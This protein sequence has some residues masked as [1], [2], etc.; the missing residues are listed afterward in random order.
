ML[1]I[2]KI[3]RFIHYFIFLIGLWY[4]IRLINISSFFQEPIKLGSMCGMLIR[5]IF[6]FILFITTLINYLNKKS[7]FRLFLF[8][9]SIIFIISLFYGRYNGSFLSFEEYIGTSKYFDR[10]QNTICK[11]IFSMFFEIRR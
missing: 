3:Y 11:D 10:N 1:F 6:Y 7:M 8:V 5:Y 2:G 9:F 4:W